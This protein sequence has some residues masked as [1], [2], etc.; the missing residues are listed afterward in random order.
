MTDQTLH[1][2]RILC[3]HG[4]GTNA[5]IFKAQ[6]RKLIAHL[7]AD[8]R[9][10]FAEAAYASQAGPDVMSVYSTWGPFKRWLRWLP[11]HPEVRPEEVVE[12]LDLSLKTAMTEDDALGATGEFVGL[13]G[14][15]QG[16]KVCASILYR[17]QES[18]DECQSRN[19]LYN[20]RFG[21]LFAGRA[22]LICLSPEAPIGISLPDASQITDVKEFTR[23]DPD[24]HNTSHVLR[25]PTLHVHGKQDP[26]LHLHR[27]LFEQFCD[28]LTRRLVVWDGNHRLPLK[29][30]DVAPI[31]HELR[32]LVEES[33]SFF[34]E[35]HH[36]ERLWMGRT[37]L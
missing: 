30:S 2:P 5:R 24:V 27:Q 36:K 26:G 12:E 33:N 15:S 1:L 35:T 34:D 4:G 13:L 17:Q 16:A 8:F 9:L 21:I 14:F 28:P 29:F 3:L 19:R 31:I 7:S 23:P 37:C 22:P 11:I 25:I 18:R 20:F 10:V 32:E 6:C